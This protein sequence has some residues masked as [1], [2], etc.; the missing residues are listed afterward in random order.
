MKFLR[1]LL[2][3][4]FFGIVLVKSEAVSW[5]RIQE[6]FHF[7]SFH[8]YGIIGSAVVTGLICVFLIRKFKM[9]TFSGEEIDIPKREFSWG[10]VIGGVLFGFGWALTGACPGPIYALFGSGIPVFLVVLLSAIAGTYVYGLLHEK[11][12]R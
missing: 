9:K 6:M 5:F 10:V 8:M 1:Y 3:G 11:L 7:K 12:P 4:M 2:A